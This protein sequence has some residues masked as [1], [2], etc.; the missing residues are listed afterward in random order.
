MK[1]TAPQLAAAIAAIARVLPLEAPADVALRAFF[2]DEK[3]LGVRD[4]AAVADLVYAVIRH[5]ERLMHLVPKPV[6]RMLAL[7]ALVLEWGVSIRELTELTKPADQEWLKTLKARGEA[8]LPD[9]MRVDLPEW[10]FRTLQAE[11]AARDIVPMMR[12]LNQPADVDL[13][14]N[15]LKATRDETQADLAKQG[16]E[17]APTPYSPFG[18]RL[19]GRA[20]LNT[21][22]NFKLGE[23]EVQDEGSQLLAMLLQPRR[24]DWVVD[25]CAGAGGKSLLLGQLMD[26]KGRIYA[27]DVS[28]KR[29]ANLSPRLKR[30]G[31]QN[32]H[33]QR[34]TAENDIKIKRLQGKIDRV[35]VDAPCTGL[36]TLRRNPDLKWRQ[37]EASL[38]SLAELQQK[39][40]VAAA[41]LVKPGG[42]LVYGTCSILRAENEAQID[43]FLA[44][45]P[46]FSLLPADNVLQ[47]LRI[48]LTTGRYL[49]LRPDQHATDGFFA[50]VLE[51]RPAVKSPDTPDPPS[52]LSAT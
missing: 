17:T 37:S 8:E 49:K 45:H 39:I 2:R 16:F 1:P 34:I 42:R 43:T 38:A 52:T 3:E 18:L 50:A 35:L 31:L 51:R 41:R 14:V 27:F 23:V 5:R 11:Y 28:E 20:D 12:A 6:P 48:N 30:S 47:A 21:T 46:D 10:I 13:R 24:S 44:T 25:F 36:G 19:K 29:L 4:R 33:A 26:S 15:T 40:L 9:H 32:I 7:A 22:R